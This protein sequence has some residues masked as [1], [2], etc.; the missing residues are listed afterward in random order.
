MQVSYRVDSAKYRDTVRIFNVVDLRMSSNLRFIQAVKMQLESQ[1]SQVMQLGIKVG[2]DC[3]TFITNQNNIAL[4]F[5]TEIFSVVVKYLTFYH[6][7]TYGSLLQ[8]QKAIQD[9]ED[10]YSKTEQEYLN[11]REGQIRFSAVDSQLKVDNASMYIQNI[12]LW[13]DLNNGT[14]YNAD[15]HVWSEDA[16]LN[17]SSASVWLSDDQFWKHTSDIWVRFTTLRT[18]MKFAVASL[19]ASRNTLYNEMRSKVNNLT[20]NDYSL[21]QELIEPILPIVRVSCPWCYTADNQTL[22][23]IVKNRMLT[24]IDGDLKDTLDQMIVEVENIYTNYLSSVATGN[25]VDRDQILDTDLL[26]LMSTATQLYSRTNDA[27]YSTL[28]QAGAFIIDLIRVMEPKC[29]SELKQLQESIRNNEKTVTDVLKDIENE[30]NPL[31]SS[32]VNSSYLYID[33]LK[34]LTELSAD[35]A[36]FDSM[37]LYVQPR[38][39]SAQ[40]LLRERIVIFTDFE[41]RANN[42]YY[43]FVAQWNESYMA[44]KS[45]YW[46]YF[47]MTSVKVNTPMQPPAPGNILGFEEYEIV[48]NDKTMY[49][50]KGLHKENIL[51]YENIGYHYQELFKGITEAS[52][53]FQTFVAGNKLDEKFYRYV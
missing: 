8:F 33:K 50:W 26:D 49:F 34:T 29:G 47:Q 44:E 18:S 6:S 28:R 31:R 5:T 39:S 17:V 37:L 23:S 30:L 10:N 36:R 46:D 19:L 3:H 27:T 22:I 40:G 14:Y 51:Q 42:L 45:L 13:T 1:T 25:T 48:P 16:V 21:Q 2:R 35:F 9:F 4:L 11:T 15:F 7:K 43:W 38:I 20:D 32:F 12:S 24:Y 53:Y 41:A 52:T